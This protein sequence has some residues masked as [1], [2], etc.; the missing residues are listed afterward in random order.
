MAVSGYNELILVN[1]FQNWIP[2]IYKQ[3]N[4]KGNLEIEDYVTTKQIFDI[5]MKYF[6]KLPLFRS[7]V[8]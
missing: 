8:N 1:N 3:F 4:V 5:L 6:K 2:F 7:S